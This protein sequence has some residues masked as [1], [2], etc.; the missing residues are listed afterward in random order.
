MAYWIIIAGLIGF[1][2]L[3]LFQLALAAGAPLGHMAWGGARRVL[4]R[5]QRVASLLSA[6]ISILGLTLMG[7]EIGFWSLIPTAIAQTL[8]WVLTALFALSLVGNA[9]SKSEIE[10][11]HG[12]PLSI[13][14]TLACVT[15]ALV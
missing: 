2:W 8:L 12:V 14:L 7:Q 1:G 11:V 3:T 10:R 4:L 13:I 6:G 9:A 15:A 5:R